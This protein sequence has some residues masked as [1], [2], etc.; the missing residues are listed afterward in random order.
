[1]QYINIMSK[2]GNTKGHPHQAQLPAAEGRILG[3]R[4]KASIYHKLVPH[5]LQ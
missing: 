3:G 2:N 5:R 1:M 4:H